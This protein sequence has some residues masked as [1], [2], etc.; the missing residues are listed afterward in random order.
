MDDT[1]R[2]FGLECIGNLDAQIKHRLDLQR[3]AIDPVSERLPFQQFHRDQGSPIE[4]VDFMDRADV[5]V[6]QGRGFGFPL[7]TTEGLRIV[8]EFVRTEF[9]GD[10]ATELQVIRLVDHTHIPPRTAVTGSAYSALE[11]SG[12]HR[13]AASNR[14]RALQSQ[15]YLP[16]GGKAVEWDLMKDRQRS[17][18]LVIADHHGNLA[19]HFADLVTVQQVDQAVLIA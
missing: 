2:V 10:V 4:L 8:G 9:Q 19:G 14:F 17:G 5:P 1:L 15:L 16:R 18:V 13:S 6:V 3:L 12:Q 11:R 7:K